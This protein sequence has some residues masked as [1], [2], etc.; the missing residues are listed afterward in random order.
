MMFP[1]AE[2]RRRYALLTDNMKSFPNIACYKAGLSDRT[3][4]MP[5]YTNEELASMSSVYKR[6]HDHFNI[7][8]NIK[9]NSEFTTA[10]SFC[11]ENHLDCIHFL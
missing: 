8:M 6:R 3:M 4:T 11:N 2:K 7:Q 1:L 10:D 5:V 9:E